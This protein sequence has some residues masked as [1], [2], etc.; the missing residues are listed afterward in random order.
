M[1]SSVEWIRDNIVSF[2]GDP[3]NMTLWGQSAG[4]ASVDAYS[5]AWADNPIVKRLIMN[6]G[7]TNLITAVDPTH[8]N[9][10]SLAA[11]VGCGNLTAVPELVC[12]RNVSLDTMIQA[13]L[14]GLAKGIS[15]GPVPDDKTV[16]SN[17]TK[18]ALEGR[19]AN[20]VCFLQTNLLWHG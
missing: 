20:I 17:Y 8:A 9:F 14:S 1:L 19:L 11:T 4:A 13:F 15:F 18:R 5:Y 2:G 16:F 3:D 6:S 12:M 10:T 7:G